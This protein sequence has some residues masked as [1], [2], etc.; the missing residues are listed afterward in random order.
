MHLNRF[1]GL[2]LLVLPALVYVTIFHYVP[3]Y[4]AMIAF[5]DF[6]IMDGIMRSPWVGLAHFRRL[7]SGSEFP[8]VIGNTFIISFLKLIFQFPTPLIFAL[9][10]NEVRSLRFKKAVQTV[11]Y[12]PHFI[13]WVVVA[14]LFIDILSP[15]RG[16]VNSLIKATGGEPIFFMGS[17][18]HFRGV[19]VA[20]EIWK[21]LGW[22]AIVYLA[23]IAGID[24]ELYQA[25]MVDGAGRFRRM[26]HVTLPCIRSTII[27][28]V[29]LR[30]GKMA[31]AGMEQIL[32]LYNPAVYQVSDIIDTYVYRI[33]FDRFELSLTAAA[34]LFKSVV[35]CALLLATDRI[36]R[37][38]GERGIY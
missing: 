8:K 25:A 6:R 31:S 33:A 7:F 22:A 2:Y 16:I 10:L 11:S 23:A 38:T 30:L 32:M 21:E 14:G 29:T 28:L 18:A 3:L 26:R 17:S 12:I 24:P 15:S 19:L 4:G 9:M 36:A 1:G 13:S 27:V 34:G 37:L 5:K 20:T 35:G